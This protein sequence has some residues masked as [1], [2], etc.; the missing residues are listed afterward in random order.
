MELCC[1]IYI[2]SL[3]QWAESSFPDYE[4]KQASV[5]ERALAFK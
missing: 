5:A 4:K 2:Q 1:K 3:S